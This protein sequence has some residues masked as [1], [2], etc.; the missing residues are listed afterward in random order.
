[1]ALLMAVQS[2]ILDIKSRQALKKLETKESLVNF[3]HL[4]PRPMKILQNGEWMLEI[5]LKK[6]GDT[7]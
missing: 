2:M 1:M 5:S 6:K 7:L 3:Q 4:H